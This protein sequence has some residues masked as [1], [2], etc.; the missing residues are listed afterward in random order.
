M[1]KVSWDKCYFLEMLNVN[2][3]N[4]SCV[5]LWIISLMS[6]IWCCLLVLSASFTDILIHEKIH[7]A[8]LRMISDLF[9][10]ELVGQELIV[11]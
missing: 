4:G 11:I 8:E 1:L 2:A 5:L 9:D 3:S 6:C 7:G 10:V